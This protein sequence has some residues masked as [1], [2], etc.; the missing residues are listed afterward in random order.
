MHTSATAF[1]AIAAPVESRVRRSNG[2]LAR[3]MSGIQ[4]TGAMLYQHQFSRDWT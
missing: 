2:N 3:Q 4:K 1:P